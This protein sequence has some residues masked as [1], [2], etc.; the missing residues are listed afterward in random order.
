MSL[1]I[2]GLAAEKIG[3]GEMADDRLGI[4]LGSMVSAGIGYFALSLGLRRR[5]ADSGSREPA[6]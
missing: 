4:L 2:S 6:P 5:R 1:F 3:L